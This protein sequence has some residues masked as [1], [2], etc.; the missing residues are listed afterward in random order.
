M[1][2]MLHIKKI[3]ENEVVLSNTLQ[4]TTSETP[5]TIIQ[6]RCKR[7]VRTPNRFMFLGEVHE[8]IPDELE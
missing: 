4:L 6:C 7:I 5:S 3:P 8:A 2:E 1:Q